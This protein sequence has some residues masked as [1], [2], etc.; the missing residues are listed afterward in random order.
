[1]PSRA[2]PSRISAIPSRYY[3]V[4]PTTFDIVT[5][6]KPIAFGF[7]PLGVKPK[8]KRK[9]PKRKFRRRPSVAAIELGF[10]AHKP[11][12]FE[13]TGLVTRPVLV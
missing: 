10:K 4:P 8:K 11:I 13:E 3:F 2:R 6:R 9:R 1:M 7:P 5:G 12:E